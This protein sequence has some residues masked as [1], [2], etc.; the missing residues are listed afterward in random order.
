M[1]LFES[2]RERDLTYTDWFPKYL[3]WPRLDQSTLGSRNSILVS[4]HR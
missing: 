3:Q 2:Q 4:Q 1:Y